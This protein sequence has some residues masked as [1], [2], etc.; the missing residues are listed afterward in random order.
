VAKQSGKK[1]S[2]AIIFRDAER[3]NKVS[4]A[5][6]NNVKKNLWQVRDLS[7]TSTGSWEPTYDTELWKQRGIISLFVQNVEQA[8]A[9]GKANMPP[10][11]IQ[12]LE[13]KPFR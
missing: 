5:V 12:V 3:G 7:Q 4:V 2:V 1:L 11:M 6:N 10:Q 9:E 8:D 13:W